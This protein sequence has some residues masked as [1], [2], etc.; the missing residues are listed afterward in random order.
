MIRSHERRQAALAYARG[1]RNA[2]L[3][4]TEPPGRER[5]YWLRGILSCGTEQ[6][7]CYERALH[8]CPNWV[9]TVYACGRAREQA[10]DVVRALEC[11]NR[12][13]S[14][15]PWF[16]EAHLG[17]ARCLQERPQ[18]AV[19]ALRRAL[20]VSPRDWPLRA[21]VERR[22]VAALARR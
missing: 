11:Y 14:L 22:L 13:R 20:E 4:A 2:A 15:N 9:L 8:M 16:A 5:I 6:I 3:V 10:G 19:A 7:E 1:D 21:I 17:V 12:A 18:D